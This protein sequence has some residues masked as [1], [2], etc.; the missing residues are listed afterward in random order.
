MGLFGNTIVNNVA[1]Y[2]GGGIAVQDASNVQVVHTTVANNDSLAVAQLAFIDPTHS[3]PQ[4]AGI[5]ARAGASVTIRNS[6]VWQNRSFSYGPCPAVQDPAH[7][8]R[9][10]STGPLRPRRST[11]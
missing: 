4:P 10:T 3:R 7:P 6:I 2:A 9:S 1:G 5:V 8:A 11:G